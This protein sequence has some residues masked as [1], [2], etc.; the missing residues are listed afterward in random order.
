M[1]KKYARP[2][3]WAIAF[4]LLYY[5]IQ[6]IVMLALTFTV[7]G[8]GSDALNA[9]LSAGEGGF[10]P[11]AFSAGTAEKTAEFMS[12]NSGIMLSISA[13]IS[14]LIF[15]AI[16]SSRKLPFFSATRLD[17]RPLLPDAIFG[18]CAGF[19]SYAIIMLA[20]SLI[21]ASGAFASQLQDYEA[22]MAFAVPNGNLAL[23][24]LGIGIITPIVEEIMF[25][26]M[27]TRELETIM[28]PKLA[29]VVQG[30]VF[31]LY[32]VQPIQILYAIP[33]G[34]YFG[35]CAYKS[36]SLWPA[37]AGHIAMNTL[38]LVLSASAA[39][40]GA[41]APDALLLFMGVSIIMFVFTLAYFIRRADPAGGGGGGG[42]EKRG[43]WG[44]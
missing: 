20:L 33:L 2:F 38:S 43:R 11:A 17:A 35:F 36:R 32:H 5:A 12:K 6:M 28:S 9:A 7:G 24:I 16:Y 29:I 30:A 31:G 25:R 14:L 44:E 23:S 4:L 42:G 1:A 3:L 34:I 40:S 10:D 21:A 27:I 22:Q 19:S 8:V 13:L 15:S 26:G 37:V 39:G 41:E 18:A